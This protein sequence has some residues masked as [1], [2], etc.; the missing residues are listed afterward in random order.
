MG[1]D[2]SNT[3]FKVFTDFAAT[4]SGRTRLAVDNLIGN[5]GEGRTIKASTNW[6][7][8]GNIGRGAE[9]QKQNNDVRTLFHSAVAELFGV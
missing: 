8:I 1:I 4:V 9:K 2:I 5:D 6:D 3:K 7:F